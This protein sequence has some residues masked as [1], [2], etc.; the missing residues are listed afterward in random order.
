[1]LAKGDSFGEAGFEGR[2]L[3]RAK[4][5]SRVNDA[6]IKLEENVWVYDEDECA[7]LVISVCEDESS[8]QKSARLLAQTGLEV[9]V[10]KEFE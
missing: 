8:A 10:S 9:K 7:Q 4:L 5:L 1:M 3:C 6:G 2:D